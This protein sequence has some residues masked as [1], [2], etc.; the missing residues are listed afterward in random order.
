MEK[1]FLSSAGA[2]I[3]LGVSKPLIE[4]LVA[5]RAI[6]SHKIGKRRRF[7]KEELIEWV[8]AHKDPK[9]DANSS[10]KRRPARPASLRGGVR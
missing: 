7:G 1:R 6:P 3:F 2:A 8:K 5:Q 10:P 9:K 4:K